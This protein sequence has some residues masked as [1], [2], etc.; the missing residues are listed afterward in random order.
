MIL[1]IVSLFLGTFSVLLVPIYVG[2]SIDAMQSDDADAKIRKIC[3]ELLLVVVVI[4]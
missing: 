3:L 4:F 1:G 2:R